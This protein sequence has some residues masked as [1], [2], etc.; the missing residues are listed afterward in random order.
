MEMKEKISVI[1]TVYNIESYLSRAVDSILAQTYQNLEVLLIDD[2]SAD[3]SGAFCDAYAKADRRVRVI[4]QANGGAYSARNTG[5]SA[6]SGELVTFVD[7]DDWIDP[8]MYE[9]LLC[10]MR[11]HRADL[12]VCRY[13]KVFEDRTVDAS[14]RREAVFEGQEL[15][16]K[17]LEEDEDWLIQTAVWN[18]LWRRELSQGLVFP[19]SLYE[20]M[21]FTIRL[22]ARSK[23]SVYLDRA[24]YNYFCGR[25]ESTTNLGLNEHT[26]DDLIPNFY[27]RSAWLTQIG[28]ADLALLQDYFLYKRLLLFYTAVARSR[29]PQKKE[30]LAFLRQKLQEGRGSYPEIFGIPQANPN[31]YRK[32]KLF[33]RSPLLYRAAMRINDSVLIPIKT[34][35]SRW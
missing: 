27:E 18:K 16:A 30:R 35:R 1:V 24:Y 23:R 34:R 5:L 2:G 22:L 6:A 21:A 28:R 10:A 33:L 25:A 3:R 4:H 14:T 13:R 9:R 20:D 26:F 17:Y 32:L 11:Q 12:A 7:G 8:D 15:L 29:D 19:K 31:E